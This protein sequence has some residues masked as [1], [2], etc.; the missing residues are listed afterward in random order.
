MALI[1][2]HSLFNSG[3]PGI[4]QLDGVM[5]WA[6]WCFGF[7]R[8]WD[9]TVGLDCADDVL[10]FDLCANETVRIADTLRTC[11]QV[12]LKLNNSKTQNLTVETQ[13]LK[14]LETKKV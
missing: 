2:V 11:L 4:P 12:G 3:Y 9:F 6:V 1:S 14:M 5:S 10:R 13:T 7:W 8:E